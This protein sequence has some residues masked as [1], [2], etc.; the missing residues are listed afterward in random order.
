MATTGPRLLRKPVD[1]ETFARLDK[2][3][4]YIARR[5]DKPLTLKHVAEKACL[6]PYHYQRMFTRAFGET[7]HEFIARKRISLAK[8]MLVD[9][10]LSVTEICFE[11]GYSSL[12]T[13]SSRFAKLVGCPPSVYREQARSDTKSRF[14][15]KFG[16]IPICLAR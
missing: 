12:G 4:Q 16:F 8:K 11:V 2:S 1:H 9:S 14:E 13:F 15:P 5:F 6:S 10:P 7:P 3:R